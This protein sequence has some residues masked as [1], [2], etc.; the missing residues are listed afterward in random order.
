MGVNQD[1]NT[2][3]T[4]KQFVFHLVRHYMY[5][6]D[7]SLLSGWTAYPKAAGVEVKMIIS[8]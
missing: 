2:P 3:P 5:I 4:Y 7:L 8:L 6:H 1:A